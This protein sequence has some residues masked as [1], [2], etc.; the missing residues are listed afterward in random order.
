M[1]YLMCFV[2]QIEFCED[3][4]MVDEAYWQGVNIAAASTAHLAVLSTCLAVRLAAHLAHPLYCPPRAPCIF[5]FCPM[6][7]V[8]CCYIH[9][10]N[11]QITWN[12]VLLIAFVCR[13]DFTAHTDRLLVTALTP[14]TLDLQGR[15]GPC[16]CP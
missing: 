14:S 1:L 13:V 4:E 9:R 10:L 15:N 3:I 7:H 2:P 16:S 12:S 5:V 11:A 6:D 8:L